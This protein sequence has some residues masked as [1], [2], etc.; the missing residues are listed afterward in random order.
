VLR[1]RRIAYSKN[2]ELTSGPGDHAVPPSRPSNFQRPMTRI[3]VAG[4]TGVLGRRAVALLLQAGHEVTAVGRTPEKRQLLDRLGARAIGVDLFDPAAVRRAVRGAEVICNLATAV[5]PGIRGL[6]LWSWRAM[7]RI[8]RQ[9][10]ANL[11]DAAL[12]TDTAQRVVQESF[13]PIYA[14]AGDWW[15]DEASVVRTARYDRS[16]LD[17]E[18]QAERFTSAGRIGVVLRFGL[19]YGPGDGFTLQVVEGVRR[20]W[21][22]L[23]GR[24]EGYW[25]WAAHEDAAAAVVAGLGVPAGIYNVGEDEPMRRRD[26]ANGMA[27]LLRVGPPRFLPRW[28]AHLGGAVGET[29]ARSL[30]I[31]NRKLK[32]ASGWAPKYPSALDGFRVIISASGTAHNP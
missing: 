9:V 24:P 27:R 30:R 23:F 14:D 2:C 3:F 17:A 11:V 10:S 20:G 28:A 22:P 26:L 21:F 12:A 18:A 4:A 8:R 7:D 6:L 13:A 31:S 15:V 19:F 1:V 25:S 32:R 29:L 5:P 16:V